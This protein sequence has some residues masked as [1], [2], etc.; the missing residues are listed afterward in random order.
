MELFERLPEL[1]VQAEDFERKARALRQIIEGVK[2]LNG[3]AAALLDS[4]LHINGGPGDKPPVGRD[5]VRRIVADRPGVWKVKDIKREAKARGF[6]ISA[7][8]VEKAVMRL[9]ETG[10]AHREGY[11]AYRFG[12]NGD[13]EVLAA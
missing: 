11:G 10:E 13:Q 7:A 6:P 9:A 1:E 2:A 4:P 5:A 3:D 12:G 8:G